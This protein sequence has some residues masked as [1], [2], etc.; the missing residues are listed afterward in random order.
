MAA[1][2]WAEM[3]PAH[4]KIFRQYMA[5]SKKHK[6]LRYKG[7]DV[8]MPARTRFKWIFPDK[9]IEWGEQM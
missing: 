2:L 5:V 9:F 6:S 3:Q 1:P 4:P 8:L 7:F